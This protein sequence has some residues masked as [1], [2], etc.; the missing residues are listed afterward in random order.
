MDTKRVQKNQVDSIGVEIECCAARRPWPEEMEPSLVATVTGDGV[1][2]RCCEGQRSEVRDI[3]PPRFEDDRPSFATPCKA[4][5]DPSAASVG[6]SVEEGKTKRM[7]SGW[8]SC[9]AQTHWPGL[10]VRGGGQGRDGTREMGSTA[11]T[12]VCVRESGAGGQGLRTDVWFRN[13]KARAAKPGPSVEYSSCTPGAALRDPAQQCPAFDAIKVAVEHGHYGFAGVR[14]PTPTKIHVYLWVRR[15]KPEPTVSMSMSTGP[16]WPRREGGRGDGGTGEG[17]R[18]AQSDE[19]LLLQRG[20]GRVGGVG[21][22]SGG[23]GGGGGLGGAALGAC[24]R[25]LELLRPLR[26][27]RVDGENEPVGRCEQAHQQ[28]AACVHG[29]A[30]AQCGRISTTGRGSGSGLG[31]ASA[32]SGGH[33]YRRRPCRG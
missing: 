1:H 24:T 19:G 17:A 9:V 13:G 16:G 6:Q 30:H 3:R 20:R 18:A 4:C 32:R 11:G 25:V 7:R 14:G 22:R 8:V 23:V 27:S 26:H 31:A 33:A 10:G 5:S 21:G 15:A 12:R 28:V 2:C 29:H